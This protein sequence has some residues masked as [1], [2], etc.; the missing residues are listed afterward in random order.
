VKIEA[1]LSNSTCSSD[2]SLSK[3]LEE[4]EEEFG[5][6]VEIVIWEGHNELFEEY[7]LTALPAVVVEELIKIIGFCPS[8]ESLV[9]ALQEVGVE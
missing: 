9:S 3:L 4:I 8:K 1:F 5:D 2:V 6:K 7:N